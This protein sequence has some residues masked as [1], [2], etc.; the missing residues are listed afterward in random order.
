M[1]SRIRPLDPDKDLDGVNA[2]GVRNGFPAFD[3]EERRRWWRSHPFRREFEDIPSGWVLEDEA[4]RIVGTFSNVPMM[5]ELDGKRWKAALASSWAVD[6]AYRSAS[7]LLAMAYLNQKGVDLCLNG[8]ANPVASRLMSATNVGRIPAEDC[9]LAFFWIIRHRAFASAFLRKKKIPGAAFLAFPASPFL[10]AADAFRRK[11]RKPGNEVRRL[12]DFGA[13]FDALWEEIRLSPGPLRAVR[14]SAALRWRFGPALRNNGALI[15]GLFR[16]N[17][18]RGYAVLSA[19]VGDA[20]DV[21]TYVLADLQTAGHS[22][23]D[24]GALIRGAIRAARDDGRD[25]LKWWGGNAEKRRIARAHRPWSYRYPYWPA[26][27]K[28]VH[29]DLKAALSSPQSWDFSLFDVF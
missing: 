29:P 27:Y 11:G 20:L 12:S 7:L 17:G 8:D 24:L 6:R 13:E 23:D 28:A 4:Q 18:L 15:L 25:A 14:T 22:P 26:Y 9:D 3:P 10:R 16:D 1:K 21:R 2:V 5:Y 19:N